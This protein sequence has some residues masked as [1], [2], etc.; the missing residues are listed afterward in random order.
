MDA[1]DKNVKKM[2]ELIEDQYKAK[3]EMIRSQ[4]LR[5]KKM[6]EKKKLCK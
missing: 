5:R 4:F 3:H 1:F 6:N 2:S